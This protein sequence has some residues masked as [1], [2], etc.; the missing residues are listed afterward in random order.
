MVTRRAVSQTYCG[1]FR[2]R[3]QSPLF[4]MSV[5]VAWAPLVQGRIPFHWTLKSALLYTSVYI[6]LPWIE[7]NGSYPKGCNSTLC[8]LHLAFDKQLPMVFHVTV[9]VPFGISAQH[10]LALWP[11]HMLETE[12]TENIGISWTTSDL[13]QTPFFNADKA[14]SCQST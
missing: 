4:P 12:T 9:F 1:A 11:T 8:R 6:I 13:V 3:T 14:I 10:D 2:T 5:K 7:R